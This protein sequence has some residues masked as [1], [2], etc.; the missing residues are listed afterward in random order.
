MHFFLRVIDSD[1]HMDPYMDC[2]PMITIFLL[3]KKRHL[4]S[5]LYK[6]K[7]SALTFLRPDFALFSFSH[8]QYL[9]SAPRL[10]LLAVT[11]SLKIYF[12]FCFTLNSIFTL[13]ICNFQIIFSILL[14]KSIHSALFFVWMLFS[15]VNL[16]W[17]FFHR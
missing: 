15:L 16:N 12:K 17:V 10:C 9:V 14:R 11:Q 1:I 13:S 4:C 3:L 2:I 8:F 7:G 6:T 5:K